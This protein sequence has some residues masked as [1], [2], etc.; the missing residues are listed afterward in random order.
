[1]KVKISA[2][3]KKKIAA[4]IVL[5][6]GNLLL[7][8]LIWLLNK[9]DNIYI[10]Q[11]LFQI[12]SPAVGANKNLLGSA[13]IRVG[14]FGIVLTAFEVFLYRLL[15]GNIKK[16]KKYKVYTKYCLSKA[17]SFFAKTA[18]PVAIATVV[19]AV[20]LFVLKLKIVPYISTVS[21]ESD[22][23]KENY[24]EPTDD[25]ITF[26]DEKKNLIYIFLESMEATYTSEAYGGAQEENYIPE[27]TDLANENVS[28]SNTDKLG[29]ALNF[30]GT[31]WTAAAMVAQ[32]S[33]I[34]IKVPLTSDNYGGENAFLPG[35]T[36][37]GEVLERNGYEQ[38]LLIGSDAAFAARDS[39]FSSH[40]N[41]NIVDIKRLKEEGRLDKDYEVFWGF[42]DNKLFEYAKEEIQ[43]LNDSGKPFNFTMLTVDTH[44]PDGYFCEKCPVKYDEQ[45]AN[46]LS[47]SSAMVY[48]FVEWIKQQPFYE[49]T[50][51]V[52]SGDHLTMDPNF[53]KS[54]DENYTR[55]VYNCI[56]NSSVNP[57]K[58]K[59]R[60]FGTF[61]MFPTTLSAMG[62]RIEGSRLGLGT[63]LF[64]AKKTLTEEYGFEVL[65]EE[66][67][68]KSTF[69]NQTFL[70]MTEKS[71][72]VNSDD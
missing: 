2:E 40:G 30:T 36:S 58:E 27:L 26:P 70:G 28:F 56:I 6:L 10:D 44:F 45:Y 59:N 33:G 5:L 64:S 54:I 65:D 48:E 37:L 13:Y 16:F 15:S 67:Q 35:I 21:T 24:V 11:I 14:F 29:G 69:Y 4:L 25:I 19:L 43:K 7:F 71:G 23:I 34:N 62:V 32:T 17:T 39:Y 42:E 55:T 38:T 49:N 68:K 72:S 50:T 66:L 46:V 57:I 1:M 8:L 3:Q 12:K 63:D 61:D 60:Q 31:T 52:I 9:Y 47:C 51:I 18:F 53:L 20:S 41:Y 22:F